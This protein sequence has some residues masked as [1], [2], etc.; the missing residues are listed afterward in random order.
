MM[1]VRF[2]LPAS[3]SS[4][5]FDDLIVPVVETF[6]TLSHET[7][8]VSV[9]VGP[10]LSLPGLPA[11]HSGK[12]EAVAGA[13]DLYSPAERRAGDSRRP[14]PLIGGPS[15]IAGTQ[16]SQVPESPMP[17]RFQDCVR[18]PELDHRA[19][20]GSEADCVQPCLVSSPEGD[21]PGSVAVTSVDAIAAL[22]QRPGVMVRARVVGSRDRDPTVREKCAC[23]GENERDSQAFSGSGCGSGGSGTGSL[24]PSSSESSESSSSESSWY[25]NSDN[26]LV[27]DGKIYLSITE[28]PWE[29]REFLLIRRLE[30]CSIAPNSPPRSVMKTKNDSFAREKKGEE[31][32]LA[33]LHDML[34]YFG[35]GEGADFLRNRKVRELCARLF[36]SYVTRTL[37]PRTLHHGNADLLEDD[38]G[39]ED[40]GGQDDVSSSQTSARYDG[41]WPEL[42]VVYRI[43]HLLA[44]S[45]SAYSALGPSFM[46]EMLCQNLVHRFH[47]H[48]SR[49]RRRLRTVIHAVYSRFK[50]RRVLLKAAIADFFLSF[51]YEC[52]EHKAAPARHNGIKELLDFYCCV[53]SGYTLPVKS[54]NIHAL[55]HILIPLHRPRNLA[56]FHRNLVDCMLEHAKKERKATKLIIR[57]L[58]R[59]WPWA[60]PPKQIL[61]LGEMEELMELL[62]IQQMNELCPVLARFLSRLLATEHCHIL[63]KALTLWQNESLV[64]FFLESPHAST[65]LPCLYTPL[66]MHSRGHRNGEV[67]AFA[68]FILDLYETTVP[69]IFQ[70]CCEEHDG[71]QDQKAMYQNEVANQWKSIEVQ[72]ELNRWYAKHHKNIIFS[73]KR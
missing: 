32:R 51:V 6:P 70:T 15:E 19:L 54:S 47:S 5:L 49:E 69:S 34:N 73:D 50:E 44:S 66:L 17:V 8:P 22:V 30:Q 60:N 62:S 48:D 20:G 55:E 12:K 1:N 43:L 56:S 61:F 18:Y 21:Q 53:V 39:S 36:H 11:P 3:K 13:N 40:G 72:A 28:V 16:T 27:H 46:T 29:A 41:R 37:P 59:L 42:K 9:A 45:D 4:D 24:S 35:T 7:S 67:R 14:G 58:L 64:N 65:L 10:G 52:D 2:E 71:E 23:T 68:K 33:A 31:S 26:E 38:E 57:S 25:Y 63:I